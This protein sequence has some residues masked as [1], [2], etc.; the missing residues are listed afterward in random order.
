MNYEPNTL[1]IL[2]SSSG[3]SQNIIKAAVKADELDLDI[4][5]LSGFDVNNKLNTFT[6]KNVKFTYHVEDTSYGVVENCH[7]VFLHSI[8]EA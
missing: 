7:Q 2:I 4:I 1:V 3:N 8:I 6:S 5:S